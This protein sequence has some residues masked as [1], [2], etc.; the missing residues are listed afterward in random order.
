MPE[1][2]EV[3]TTARVLN[4]TIAGRTIR[5]VW[6]G[7][8][9]FF[10]RSPERG[11]LPQVLIGQR[12]SRVERRGKFVC[13][14]FASGATLAI[15]QKMSGR[16][17]V[18][19]VSGVNPIDPYVRFTMQLDDKQTVIFSDKR[20]FGRGYFYPQAIG[21]P[22]VGLGP[23]ALE[24]AARPRA[25][26]AR[27]EASRGR[28]K[29]T[30]LNQSVLAGVGN[31]YADEILWQAQIHPSRLVGAIDQRGRLSLASATRLVLAKALR[32]GG[33]S[34]RDYLD[35]NRKRGEYWDVRRVYQRTGEPCPRCRAL[36]RKIT[37]AG[38]GT[39][40]C[41]RCQQNPPERGLR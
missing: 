1:L 27:L 15:H 20:K 7:S 12:L 18:D 11:K 25:F 2:P 41:P 4:R 17:F 14:K 5:S 23:D 3:E 21:A 40:Y 8:A 13:F 24:L 22:V 38:R 33:T 29:P 34:F 30:L 39:H 16:L 19:N 26:A 9:R 32:Y 10:E 35:P 36:I 37:M 6:L 28:I 31:L